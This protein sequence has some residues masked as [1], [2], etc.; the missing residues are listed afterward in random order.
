VG[1]EGAANAI[2]AMSDLIVVRLLRDA[3]RT[4]DLS[5]A[6]H[7]GAAVPL[8]RD[9]PIGAHA[10]VQPAPHLKVHPSPRFEPRP[11]IHPTPRFEPRVVVPAPT[12]TCDPV[13]CHRRNNPIEP[14]WRKPV[15]EIHTP[16]PAKVKVNLH[17][18][19]VAHK[20]SLIDLFI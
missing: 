5:S 16:P 19:D 17:R 18:T 9:G 20:G 7:G 14:V 6:A 8:R 11:V 10:N 13:P 3:I 1:L 12:Y 15:W 2:V 4:A